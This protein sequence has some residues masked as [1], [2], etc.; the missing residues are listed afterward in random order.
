[1]TPQQQQI[2][3]RDRHLDVAAYALGILSD[4][5]ATAF[6][7][8]LAECEACQ[9]ELDELMDIEPVLAEYAAEYVPKP[10]RPPA[11]RPRSPTEEPMLG[12]LIDR[13]AANRRH[14]RVRRIYALAA[15]VV[16]IAGG[17][18]AVHI[19]ASGS[20]AAGATAAGLLP[21]SGQQFSA[22]NAATGISATVGLMPMQ[23]GTHV[24]LKLSGIKGPLTCD[25]VAVSDTGQ[26]QTVA[27]WQVP[28]S[29]Y[30]V[31]GSEAPLALNGGA[32]MAP[33]DISSF[34]VQTTGGK[35][36]LNIPRPR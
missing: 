14:S 26:R 25:L 10:P 24:A 8:H 2:P 18:L 34:E 33:A 7:A 1:M 21:V 6:E 12:Q 17:P 28:A 11:T 35:D 29:G 9:T 32:G 16:L 30:G 20:A 5:E 13:V 15:A 4:A 36:L 27:T 22:A 19:L 23:W 3:D 31:T